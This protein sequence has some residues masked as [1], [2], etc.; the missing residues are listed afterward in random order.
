M[1]PI[2][3]IPL[4]VKQF[5]AQLAGVF[6]RQEQ[7]NSFEA[8]ITGLSI[9]ENRTIAGIHQQFI[10]G[11]TYEQLH[12]FMTDSPWTVEKLAESRMLYMKGYLSK[13]VRPS[14]ASIVVASQSDGDTGKDQTAKPSLPA[15]VTSA[16]GLELVSDDSAP[17]A[18]GPDFPVVA[19]LDAT[20]GHHVGDK[21][22]GVYWYWD[23]AQRRYCLA[24]RLVLSTLVTAEK[25]IPLGWRLFH[26]GFL[27]EQ[28]L[29]LE[30]VQP[31]PDA[32]QSAWDEYNDLVECHE[33]NKKEHKK[34]HE[35]AMELVD[36]NERLCLKIDVYVCDAALAVPELMDRIDEYGKAWVSKLSKNRLVQ[37]A[38]GGYESIE[39]FAK[40]LPKD[41]FKPAEVQTRHGQKRTYYCFTKS[42]VVKD[43]K[44]L[45]VVISYDNQNLEGEPIYLITNRKQ[46]VQPKKIVQLYMMRDPIEHLIRDVK[47]EVGFEDS[48][49]R[50]EDGV[51]KH[52]ELS[53]TA[54]TFLEIGL[55][56]PTLSGV[57]TVRLETI[58]QKSRVMEGTVLQGLVNQVEQLVLEGKDTKELVWQAMTKRLNRLA[59]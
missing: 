32:A 26:R 46:W 36:E 13:L 14:K 10:D 44:K 9:A 15:E 20:F 24:Q 17:S 3:S 18:E 16:N 8:M 34:Q 21:I 56:V 59:T 45:R 33:R 38:K 29:Y 4:V 2:V 55:N 42:V 11:P 5:C 7:R 25:Q 53:F 12:H 1:L 27:E 41:V 19:T 50:K 37:T 39:S 54:Y 6:A 23:Y 35:L 43:W 52:W 28:K 31:T 57:P 40:T 58:G 30:S 48:Q 47:Q 22:Y 49:Q 51:K